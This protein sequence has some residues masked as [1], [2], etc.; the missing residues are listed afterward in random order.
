MYLTSKGI[1]AT[2]YPEGHESRARAGQRVKADKDKGKAQAHS[3][4]GESDD[5]DEGVTKKDVEESG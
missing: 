2:I 1:P 3:L 4:A 5:E